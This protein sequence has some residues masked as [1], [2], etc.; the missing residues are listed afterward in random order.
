MISFENTMNQHLNAQRWSLGNICGF[1]ANFWGK[2]S[3]EQRWVKILPG[4]SQRPTWRQAAFEPGRQR[5][6]VLR[7]YMFW[8]GFLLFFLRNRRSSFEVWMAIQIEWQME[9]N[10]KRMAARKLALKRHLIEGLWGTEGR[11]KAW[12]LDLAVATARRTS[13]SKRVEWTYQRFNFQAPMV[14]VTFMA[15]G[16]VA[17]DGGEK[18]AELV[19]LEIGETAPIKTTRS[20]GWKHTLF[21]LKTYMA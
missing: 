17:I 15:M 12:K 19:R 21:H 6:K 10:C 2:K 5:K 4:A 20:L 11:K 9:I 8:R 16:T 13:P 7:W 18:T 1:Q 3:L 14:A